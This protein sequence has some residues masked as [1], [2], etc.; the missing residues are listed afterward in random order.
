MLSSIDGSTP[1][2]LRYLRS[3]PATTGRLRSS[4]GSGPGAGAD[5]SLTSGWA[6]ELDS[7]AISGGVGFTSDILTSGAGAG[8]G[9]GGFST[10]AGLG[11]AGTTAVIPSGPSL[12]SFAAWRSFAPAPPA[13]GLKAVDAAAAFHKAPASL[14]VDCFFLI[15]GPRPGRCSSSGERSESTGLSTGLKAESVADGLL[16]KAPSVASVRGKGAVS[17]G[18]RG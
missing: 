3:L 8:A 4:L 1:S 9:S 14:F 5:A 7:T 17:S 11:G 13:R 15:I 2:V 16:V 18:G 12:C 10:D 6:S